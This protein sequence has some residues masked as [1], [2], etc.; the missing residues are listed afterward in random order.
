MEQTLRIIDSQRLTVGESPVW[1]EQTSRLYTID[2]RG[3]CVR[4]TDWPTGDICQIDLPQ[5]VGCVALT[6][7]GRLIA[8]MEDGIYLVNNGGTV[9]KINGEVTI[10][11][12][13]FN[14]G[15]VDPAGRVWGG[16]MPTSLDTG[17]G[18][19][20]PDSAVYCMDENLQ[21]KTMLTGVIQGNGLA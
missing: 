20:G 2:I 15:K 13:R 5:Q 16:T 7:D 4:V 12:R 17:Y 19:A 11:G 3:K 18:E 6:E 21:V 1:D 9:E 8:A 14:D 10:L